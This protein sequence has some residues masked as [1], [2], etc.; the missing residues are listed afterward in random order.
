MLEM[1]RR[2]M[3]L[4]DRAC[5]EYLDFVQVIDQEVPPKTDPAPAKPDHLAPVS[6]HH[7]LLRFGPGIDATDEKHQ[8]WVR[9]DCL[10][11]ATPFDL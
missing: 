6:A 1:I 11:A 10:I 5:S 4:L 2:N 8:G 7:C 3:R 9:Q